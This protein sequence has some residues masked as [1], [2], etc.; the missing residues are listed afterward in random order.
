MYTI[1]CIKGAYS[2]HSSRPSASTYQSEAA[3]SLSSA[4]PHALTVVV[5]LGAGM[6]VVCRASLVLLRVW[7]SGLQTGKGSGVRI[8]S[9]MTFTVVFPC[10]LP[11]LVFSLQ[12]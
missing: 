12:I 5:A 8:S 2:T 6:L 4:L 9:G 1:Q 3:Q 11:F 7:E 10:T